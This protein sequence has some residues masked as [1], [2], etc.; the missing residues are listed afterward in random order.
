MTNS[1]NIKQHTNDSPLTC[2]PYP[3]ILGNAIYSNKLA[4]ETGSLHQSRLQPFD[5]FNSQKT[6]VDQDRRHLE[7]YLALS[8]HS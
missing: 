5:S 4:D 2:P 6:H 8:S 3:D 1:L 7:G